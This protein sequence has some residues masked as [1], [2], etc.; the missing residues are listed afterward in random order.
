MCL[1]SQCSALPDDT[2][3]KSEPGSTLLCQSP[4]LQH[5]GRIKKDWMLHFQDGTPFIPMKVA[6]WMHT[7]KNSPQAS[8]HVCVFGTIDSCSLAPSPAE[9]AESMHV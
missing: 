6:R 3:T 1:I 2:V 7:A 9:P 5:H 8:S 4:L